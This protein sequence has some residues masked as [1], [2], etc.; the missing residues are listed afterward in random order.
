MSAGL[1]GQTSGNIALGKICV[2]GPPAPVA[3]TMYLMPRLNSEKYEISSGVNLAELTPVANDKISYIAFVADGNGNFSAHN[4]VSDQLIQ[5]LKTSDKDEGSHD[6]SNDVFVIS[7]DT[8]ASKFT[9]EFT[10][11]GS[12]TLTT[13]D[14]ES[15][16]VDKSKL[17][18]LIG[19]VG[20]EQS[21]DARKVEWSTSHNSTA[22]PPSVG[23]SAATSAST[24]AQP[25]KSGRLATAGD[26]AISAVKRLTNRTSTPSSEKKLTDVEKANKLAKEFSEA[27]TALLKEKLDGQIQWRSA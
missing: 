15:A 14:S 17:G 3:G 9:I 21:A 10:E 18:S 26:K 8:D 6:L 25:P 4:V 20:N 11:K 5:Q 12:D 23:P 1:Q 13:L 16:T 24:L 7:P 19:A 2:Q 22:T 27:E